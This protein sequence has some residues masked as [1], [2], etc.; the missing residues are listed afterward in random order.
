MKC[1]RAFSCSCVWMTQ[2]QPLDVFPQAGAVKSSASNAGLEDF[3]KIQQPNLP[4]SIFKDDI[5]KEQVRKTCPNI[6]IHT[7]IVREKDIYMCTSW[8]WP[9]WSNQNP[10]H[11]ILIYLIILILV[12]L[13]SFP[14]FLHLSAAKRSPAI[15]FISQIQLHSQERN[16][17]ISSLTF[18]FCPCF[19]ET[20]S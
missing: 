8:T 15:I 16:V 17:E 19:R 11:E 12:L 1:I 10:C 14:I 2:W 6:I 18:A 3:L 7:Y 5:H 13:F 20:T 4:L 9:V